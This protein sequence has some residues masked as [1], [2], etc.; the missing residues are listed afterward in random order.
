M[1]IVGTGNST[2]K[3][4]KVKSRVYLKISVYSVGVQREVKQEM[5]ELTWGFIMQ[6]L[7]TMVRTFNLVTFNFF[8]DLF[9]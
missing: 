6:G 7:I 5:G 1:R 4:Q 9:Y 3:D 8:P 2:C